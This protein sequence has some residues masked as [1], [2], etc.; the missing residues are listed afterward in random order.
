[1]CITCTR[2]SRPKRRFLQHPRRGPKCYNGKWNYVHMRYV[3]WLTH[4]ATH[5]GLSA[6]LSALFPRL[7][8]L[9]L[10]INLVNNLVI[11]FQLEQWNFKVTRTLYIGQ[12]QGIQIHAI[13]TPNRQNVVEFE[14]FCVLWKY[15]QILH[16]Y[17]CCDA[18]TFLPH[19]C[20][21]HLPSYWSAISLIW[22]GVCVLKRK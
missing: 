15:K 3:I 19:F 4:T 18:F 20:P 11:S 5:P 22:D 14:G 2:D 6:G 10:V 17:W 13:I 1:M 8:M 16:G 21:D 7:H 12:D 9:H